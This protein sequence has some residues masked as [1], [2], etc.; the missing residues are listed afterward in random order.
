[1]YFSKIFSIISCKR[2]ERQQIESFPYPS[3]P[4]GWNCPRR[5]VWY[6]KNLVGWAF[7][8]TTFEHRSK[9]TFSN[10]LCFEPKR[11]HPI[12]FTFWQLNL[13]TLKLC[14]PVTIP[15]F[16]L[17]GHKTS[18]INQQG[19]YSLRRPPKLIIP[20]TV[21]RHWEEMSFCKHIDV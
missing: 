17:Y 21:I 13:I 11:Y 14:I 1:M 3:L 15:F 16:T 12:H 9:Y 8:K 7:N 10:D 19:N 2:L 6:V 4:W 20:Q 5:G 18:S